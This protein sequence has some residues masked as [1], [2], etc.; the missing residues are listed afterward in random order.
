MHN[1]SFEK[2]L[3]YDTDEVGITVEVKISSVDSET[4]FDAKI[5]TGA[6][7]CIFNRRFGEEI[8][9]EIERGDELRFYTATDSFLT[10]GHW[11]NWLSKI[12]SLTLMYFLPPMKI[13]IEMFSA[14]PAGSTVCRSV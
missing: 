13:S 6:T 9:V 2:L 12:S 10:Y 1:L 7:A 14:E 3:V 11:V 8:G 5:D 4:R